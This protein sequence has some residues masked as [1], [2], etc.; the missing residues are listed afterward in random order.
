MILAYFHCIALC[1]Y[2]EDKNITNDYGE[3]APRRRQL[4]NRNNGAKCRQ[5]DDGAADWTNIT[6]GY[7]NIRHDVNVSWL[8]W[9]QGTL[10][11][12]ASVGERTHCM[13]QRSRPSRYPLGIRFTVRNPNVS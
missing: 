13:S 1:S 6:Q 4:K 12:N 8:S 5:T 3:R 2:S 10:D 11:F 9:I 7:S